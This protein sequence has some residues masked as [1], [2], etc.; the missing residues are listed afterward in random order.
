MSRAGDHSALVFGAAVWSLPSVLALVVT[1][2]VTRGLGAEGY[3]V[4]SWSSAFVAFGLTP[5]LGRAL[6]SR[7][8]SRSDPAAGLR[9]L[10]PTTLAVSSLFLPVSGAI[11]T[12]LAL[13]LAPAG[14]QGRAAALFVAPAVI[15]TGLQQ[16]LLAIPQAVGRFDVAARASVAASVAWTV[17][18]VAVAVAKGSPAAFTLALAAG[19]LL[20]SALLVASVRRLV[21]GLGLRPGNLGKARLVVGFGGAVLLAH[22]AGWLYLLLERTALVKLASTAELTLL[23]APMALALQLHAAAWALTRGFLPAVAG[24]TREERLRLY[25]EALVRV[26]P[27]V[28]VAAATI[29]L[30]AGPILSAW[31]GTDW[32]LDGRLPLALLALAFGTLAVLVVPWELAEAAGAPGK[33]AAF[34]VAWLL[35]GGVTTL[36]LVPRLGAV[37]ASLGRATVVLLAIPFARAAERAGLG[38]PSGRAWRPA[39]VRAAA[40]GGGAAVAET[41]VLRAAGSGR[42]GLALALL[43]GTPFLL[44]AARPALAP[45]FPGAGEKPA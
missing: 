42:L 8:A 10:V 38:A 15:A 30:L 21:P 36:V 31:L 16:V 6:L 34:C 39:L 12:L 3:G 28:A 26:V 32:A 20:S 40:F 24:A 11:L 27:P 37:G 44:A 25:S 1:P 45:F 23:A 13:A 35:V 17:S 41:L 4:W 29:A 19:P 14:E 7:C 33:T 22:V 5:V 9:E 2:V 18:A 43:A